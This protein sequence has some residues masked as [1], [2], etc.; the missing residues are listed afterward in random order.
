MANGE[1]ESVRERESERRKNRI[2]LSPS[3]IQW[4]LGC[5]SSTK[6]G[7]SLAT[8]VNAYTIRPS[9]RCRFAHQTHIA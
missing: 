5:V 7:T 4:I 1:E 9:P 3:A 2:P 6:A 8:R